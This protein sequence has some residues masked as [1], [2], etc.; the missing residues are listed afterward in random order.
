M[1]EEKT[2]LLSTSYD[3][4]LSILFSRLET[5]NTDLRH[6]LA[7]RTAA[8]NEL[9]TQCE[10]LQAQV[11]LLTSDPS[12][13]HIRDIARRTRELSLTI[14]KERKQHAKQIAQ[15]KETMQQQIKQ[16]QIAAAATASLSSTLPLSL[17]S[18]TTTSSSTPNVQELQHKITLLT[19]RSLELQQSLHLSRT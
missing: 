17:T 19:S 4:S 8:S 16:E 18:S 13:A 3:P 1:M 10:T 11:D 9:L 5:D 7:E 2:S 6:Q 15:M 12:H 14:S